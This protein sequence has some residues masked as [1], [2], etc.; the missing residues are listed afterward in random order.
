MSTCVFLEEEEYEDF[1][2][3]VP[4]KV[5]SVLEFL[6]D[7]KA[8]SSDTAT[9]HQHVSSNDSESEED[10][11][12]A[13]TLRSLR[14]TPFMTAATVQPRHCYCLD[15]ANC[16]CDSFALPPLLAATHKSTFA[17]AAPSSTAKY[18]VL[19]SSL[20]DEGRVAA[21]AGEKVHYI[22]LHLRGLHLA[23]LQSVTAAP[24]AGDFSTR[25]STSTTCCRC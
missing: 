10:T 1:T 24:V 18:G 14:L 4:L 5:H 6:E 16:M 21:I 15:K 17:T 23:K 22:P 7:T 19:S 2:D 13:E 12:S 25:P 8:V 20:P 9:E 11:Q 3:D